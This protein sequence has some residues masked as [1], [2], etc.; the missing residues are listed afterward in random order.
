MIVAGKFGLTRA[1]MR[2]PES[3]NRTKQS[4]PDAQD[5]GQRGHAAVI[6]NFLWTSENS[7]PACVFAGGAALN[8]KAAN[9]LK[10]TNLFKRLSLKCNVIS[11]RPQPSCAPFKVFLTDFIPLRGMVIGAEGICLNPTYLHNYCPT[12]AQLRR[13]PISQSQ[14]RSDL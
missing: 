9:R 3:R 10:A 13:R 1:A 2:I 4:K 7:L 8:G 5:S 6:I 12:L 14:T 11:I